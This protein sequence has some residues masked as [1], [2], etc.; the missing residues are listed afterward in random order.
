MIQSNPRRPHVA[1]SVSQSAHAAVP[2]YRAERCG[3]MEW[4]DGSWLRWPDVYVRACA[5]ALCSGPVAVRVLQPQSAALAK[6]VGTR[7]HA[8]P[9]TQ[10]VCCRSQTAVDGKLPCIRRTCRRGAP[11]IA[12][13]GRLLFLAAGNAFESAGP[14]APETNFQDYKC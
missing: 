5:P 11:S 7:R 13:A 10:H 12:I 6:L 2:S 8:K 9:S 1:T 3:W 4:M 14:P